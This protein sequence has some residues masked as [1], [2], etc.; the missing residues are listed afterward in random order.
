ML[1]KQDVIILKGTDIK[2]NREREIVANSQFAIKNQHTKRKTHSGEKTTKHF[3]FT[4]C[5]S[6]SGCTFST[7]LVPTSYIFRS[8]FVIPFALPICPSSIQFRI[9][10]IC[11]ISPNMWKYQNY[12]LQIQKRVFSPSRR[13]IATLFQKCVFVL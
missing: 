12:Q 3:N 13:H 5:F 1:Q 2:S 7:F 10:I 9:F 4:L 11:S 6:P 8:R